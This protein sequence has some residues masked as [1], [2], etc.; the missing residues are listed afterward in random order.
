MTRAALDSH[1]QATFQQ[2]LEISR[3]KSRDYAGDGN[4][5]QNF[6]L[7]E[8]LGLCTVEHGIMV[9]ISDKISRPATLL[10]GREPQ[11]K[12][13]SVTDTIRDAINYLAILAAY[14]DQRN[15]GPHRTI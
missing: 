14:L 2:C 9:R 3:R 6:R 13:E 15:K 1:M 8:F 11:V 7:V 12:D 10:D 4:P 5:F